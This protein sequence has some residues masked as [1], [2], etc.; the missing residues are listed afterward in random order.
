[1]RWRLREVRV[2]NIPQAI[3]DELERAGETVIANALAAPMDVPGSP[4]HKFR[5]GE[6]RPAAEAWLIERRDIAE[7]K[8][9][10]AERWVS[11]GAFAAIVAAGA[12]VLLLI[13]QKQRWDSEDRPQLVTSGFAISPDLNKYQWEFT[14]RGKE[15][16]TNIKIMIAKTD[17]NHTKTTPL[18]KTSDASLSVR[19]LIV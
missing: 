5:F 8:E 4:F 15:D 19:I 9:Q 3:R 1:M 13:W 6:E 7:R 17:L 10:R 2:A 11:T 16:A 18:T 12:A 14:N